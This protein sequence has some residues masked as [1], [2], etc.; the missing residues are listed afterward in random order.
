MFNVHSGHWGGGGGGG[1]LPCSLVWTLWGSSA[2]FTGVDVIWGC[3]S[4]RGDCEVDTTPKLFSFDN[5]VGLVAFDMH[6]Q[7]C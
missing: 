4:S 5:Q 7:A 2:I 1:V 3:F 6:V